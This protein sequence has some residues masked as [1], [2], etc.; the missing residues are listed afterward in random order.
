MSRY[1]L[2]NFAF[3]S[4]TRRIYCLFGSTR[5]KGKSC[6]SPFVENGFFLLPR[7]FV[8]NALSVEWCSRESSKVWDRRSAPRFAYS[9][10]LSAS[11]S[12]FRNFPIEK[13]RYFCVFV[14]FYFT[15]WSLYAHTWTFLEP[16]FIGVIRV[17]SVIKVNFVN[18]F[19]CRENRKLRKTDSNH[20]SSCRICRVK[21]RPFSI[22]SLSIFNELQSLRVCTSNVGK[23][24]RLENN[25]IS[26]LFVSLSFRYED[27]S[28]NQTQS[29]FLEK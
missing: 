18:G 11:L 22:A 15:V 19:F 1:R 27:S 9:R 2:S 16:I 5:K 7:S 6:H 21:L 28:I 13:L 14:S 26:F 25:N 4:T 17:F 12:H 24:N 20:C 29:M 8:H 10:M 23:N 3:T